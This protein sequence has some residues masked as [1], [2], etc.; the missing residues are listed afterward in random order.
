[1]RSAAPRGCTY[2][3]AIFRDIN[4]GIP[5]AHHD[6]L[7]FPDGQI[8]LLT[9][10]HEGQRATVLQLPATHERAKAAQPDKAKV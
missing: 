7:E 4:Q 10:L 1:M 8:V 9:L 6:A 3:T 5:R 2:K